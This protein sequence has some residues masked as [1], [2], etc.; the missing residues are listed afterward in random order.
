MAATAS[1]SGVLTV[2]PP[3]PVVTIVRASQLTQSHVINVSANLNPV[4]DANLNHGSKS[5][6]KRARER[7]GFAW[8]EAHARALSVP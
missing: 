4:A 7:V 1:V 2:R 3:L 8:R 6:A 5:G